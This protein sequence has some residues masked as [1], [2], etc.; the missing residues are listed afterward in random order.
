MTGPPPPPPPPPFTVTF[1]ALATGNLHTCGLTTTHAAYCWG[2][3]TSGQ[4]PGGTT[5][6]FA[7]SPVA[8]AGAVALASLSGGAFHSCGLTTGGAAYCGAR[9]A[10]ACWGPATPSRT[11]RRWRW[12]VP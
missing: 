10:S 12:P 3:N 6:P 9:T 7:S 5:L 4:L 11:P 2:D 8:V 1:T